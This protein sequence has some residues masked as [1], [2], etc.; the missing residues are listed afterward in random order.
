MLRRLKRQPDPEEVGKVL[1]YAANLGRH[2]ECALLSLEVGRR[3]IAEMKA[4]Y[5]SVYLPQ[6][7]LLADA[8]SFLTLVA[9]CHKESGG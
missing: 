7:T 1:G 9:A 2:L 3:P 5:D 6:A 4:V 8:I